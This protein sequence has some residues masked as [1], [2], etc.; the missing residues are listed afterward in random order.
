MQDLKIT[1]E[2]MLV[3]AVTKPGTIMEAYSAFH[4]YSLGNQM[5]AL[6]QCAER[7]IT[8]GPIATFVGWKEKGR[9]V[10]RGQKAI[11]LCMPITCKSKDNQAAGEE[12]ECFTRFIFRPNWFVLSQTDGADYVAPEIAGF[13]LER[14]LQA[15]E[16]SR[17]EFDYPDGNAQ[18]YA[19]GRKFAIN[20]V[21]QLP[22]RTTFHELGHIVLGHTAEA[23]FADTDRTPRDIREAEAESVALLC[24]ES[25]GLP[26]ADY[27]RGYIQHWLEGSTIPERSAQKI[28]KAAD[29]ILK[30]GAGELQTA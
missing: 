14:A 6:M 5:L 16:I 30:A 28:F 2:S 23:S 25:L 13:D 11:V 19:S 8:P 15:L 26:G 7:G 20:P 21:A 29:Q 12:S 4:G 9:F 22:I 27:A 10:C 17:I 24:C 1:W 18:G 3:E